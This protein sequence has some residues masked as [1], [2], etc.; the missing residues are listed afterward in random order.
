MSPAI[1]G[2]LE[3]CFADLMA[4]S[5]E[6]LCDKTRKIGVVVYDHDV[7]HNRVSPKNLVLF[8]SIIL[9]MKMKIVDP[10][11]THSITVTQVLSRGDD[12]RS[13]E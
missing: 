13:P 12:L 7:R 2:G 9:N 4:D 10:T 5:T 3:L 8:Y 1:D 6:G 11:N